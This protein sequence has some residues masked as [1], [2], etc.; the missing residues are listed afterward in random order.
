MHHWDKKKADFLRQS[1]V[2]REKRGGGRQLTLMTFGEGRRNRPSTRK[3]CESQRA[4]I[5]LSSHPLEK[6]GGGGPDREPVLKRSKRQGKG[7]FKTRGEYA[8]GRTRRVSS[9]RT[10]K[11]NHRTNWIGAGKGIDLHGGRKDSI[12]LFFLTGIE[13]GGTEQYRAN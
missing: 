9:R 8:E 1:L 12:R 10:G 3:V 11:G 6:K 5:S 2:F 4:R 7:G 13:K